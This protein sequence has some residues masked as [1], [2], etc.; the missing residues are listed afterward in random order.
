MRQ[1]L[2]PVGDAAK[3]ATTGLLFWGGA[4]LAS[5]VLERSETAAV[6]V[7]A[8]IAEW[9]A[10]MTG[11]ARSD[12]LRPAPSRRAILRRV[13]YGLALGL[14][15]SGII[16]GAAIATRA[17][18]VAQGSPS[19]GMLA[20]GLLV[21]GLAAVRDELL[22][23]GFVLR[24]MRGLIGTSLAIAV[25]GG[26][27]A[28]ARLGLDGAVTS[29]VLVEALRGVA[30]GVIWVHDR[31]AWMAVAANA[32]WTWALGPLTHGAVFDLR[33][34]QEPDA[35]PIA[36]AVLAVVATAAFV[37]LG[38]GTVDRAGRESPQPR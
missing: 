32:G 36:I 29:A 16:V 18:T 7:Q 23:R 8:A 33:F 31:G 22:L 35:S 34:R 15:V 13:A 20:I 24:A 1:R 9:G 3:V 14:G 38:R 26:A 17:A 21:G 5:T 25:C 37:W 10:G 11:I 30:L 28:A 6:A 4:Q 12:P 19:I 27:A 2:G